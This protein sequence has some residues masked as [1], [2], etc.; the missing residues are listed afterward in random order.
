MTDPDKAAETEPNEDAA[1]QEDPSS[2]DAEQPSVGEVKNLPEQEMVRFVTAIKDPVQQIGE[3]IVGALQHDNTVAVLTTV[4]VG[5]DG[6]QHIVSAA[7]NPT[8]ASQINALLAGA[9]AEREVE[10]PC[11][12]FHCLLKPKGEESSEETPPAT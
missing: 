10:E 4:V 9:A 1:S 12:G 7:I 2:P 5:P 11:I 6:K 3:H 8:Q